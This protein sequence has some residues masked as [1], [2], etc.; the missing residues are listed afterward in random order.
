M[1]FSPRAQTKLGE[2]NMAARAGENERAIAIQAEMQSLQ[3]Q[4]GNTQVATSALNAQAG[5]FANQMN[6]AADSNF[7]VGSGGSGRQG[8]V[9]VMEIPDD[10]K[11]KPG[12]K[13]ELFVREDPSLN[14][15]FVVRNSG[16]IHPDLGRVELIGMTQQQ[17]EVAIKGIL[18]SS[19]LRTAT[20]TVERSYLPR[21][22]VAPPIGDRSQ[23]TQIIPPPPIKRDIVYLAGEFLTPGP[24]LIP[25]GVK[26]TLLQTIIRSGG[27][28]PSGD[29]MRVKLLRVV[30][31]GQGAVQEVNV[32]AILSGQEP[33]EDIE[34]KDG[35]IV[36]IPPFA[37][38]V[39]VTGNVER[40]G[41]LRL[42]QDETLTAYAAILRAGGFARFASIKRVYV[43][44]DLGNG[45]KAHLPI[46][47]RDVEGTRA[48]CRPSRQGHCRRAGTFLQFLITA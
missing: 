44:R 12:D 4:I 36:V 24:L 32:S 29:M 45:E 5:N 47:I 16:L 48:G 6:A 28:T 33:P 1:N 43:V 30:K 8:G 14:G 2:Y 39:Y 41:T 46:N 42:F 19:L 40:P 27:I 10:G 11:F 20:V 25:P 3:T 9:Q 26:P 22:Y 31:N 34:L 18:E 21:T 38:V 7:Q 15:E 13:L 37:P 35:D 17:A 23:G